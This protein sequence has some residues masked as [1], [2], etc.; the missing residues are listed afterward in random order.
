MTK[1][2]A[3]E[4]F[5]EL[6]VR[7]YRK[8]KSDKRKRTDRPRAVAAMREER[9]YAWNMIGNMWDHDEVNLEKLKNIL[10]SKL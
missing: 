3:H 5:T 10:Q 8:G 6:L 7:A 9:V 2:E 1:E 4:I